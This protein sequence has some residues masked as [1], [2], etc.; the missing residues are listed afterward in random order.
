MTG[1][2]IHAGGL[3][4]LPILDGTTL[5]QHRPPPAKRS[6]QLY[7]DRAT[8]AEKAG[9]GTEEIRALALAMGAD[10]VGFVSV[11]RDEMA[12]QRAD[13]EALLP[14]ARTL[15]AFVVA[16]NRGNVRTP[17]RSVAN[18]EF[19]QGIDE[20]D[21]VSR[22]IARELESRGHRAVSP[23][24]GFPMEVDRFPG[25]IWT[26]S[27][28]PIAVA[29]GLGHMG[30]H[31]N[32]IHP[33][34][35]NFILI[36]VVL[37]DL[38]IGEDE[39]TQPLEWNPCMGCRLCVAACPVGA[40]KSDGGFDFAACTTH[41]YREF[42]GGFGD[43]VDTVTDSDGHAEYGK[44]VSQSETAS[45]W[46]SLSFGANYKAAYC[47]AVCP[48]GDDVIGP[49]L[50]DQKRHIAEVVKPL[51]EKQEPVYVVAGSDA[52]AHVSARFPHK[53][54]RQVKNGFAPTS[55]EAF[56]AGSPLVFSPRAAKGVKLRA[57]FIFRG[58]S[59]LKVTYVIDE[60]QLHLDEGLTGT[61]D[62]A[63]DVD[64]QTWVGITRGEINPVW[65]VVTRKLR[66]KGPIK[67][68]KTFQQCFP[69]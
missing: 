61:P 57:H 69:I 49:Y 56:V 43:W 45:V 67:N 28:K 48:A 30:I 12:V 59:D 29:A 15:I 62:V 11:D 42:L 23:P 6:L 41:N 65:A 9:A 52:E 10:D 24:G 8:G 31:R 16:M 34:F 5:P 58:D 47:M 26:L 60:E 32:V 4:S 64:A 27:M 13:I 18:G 1:P 38:E 63:V 25:K 21:A 54:V 33:K 68:L 3:P 50:K 20:A 40:V 55:V 37:T 17:A 19:H 46:Q 36:G 35:G 66:V 51:T 39:Q 14:G 53:Q 2:D 7:A 44:K 22:G